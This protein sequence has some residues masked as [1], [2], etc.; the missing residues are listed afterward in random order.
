VAGVG[1]A[2]AGAKQNASCATEIK[3]DG[4]RHTPPP[5]GEQYMP[6]ITCREPTKTRVDVSDFEKKNV[7]E[8]PL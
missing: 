5:K 7:S 4:V 2:Q 3:L 8:L 6:E 1:Y